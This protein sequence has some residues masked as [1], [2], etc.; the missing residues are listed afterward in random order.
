MKTTM[1]TPLAIAILLRPQCARGLSIP[2]AI[3]LTQRNLAASRLL[4][5]QFQTVD[6]LDSR[7]SA[8]AERVGA[9][10]APNLAMHEHLARRAGSDRLAYFA[11]LADDAFSA[12]GRAIASL[13]RDDVSDAENYQRQRGSS[14]VYDVTIYRQVG[15]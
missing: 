15:L 14:A 3:F 7:A 13:A 2:Y 1:P 8:R 12:G 10:G 4:H 5:L 11:D 9:D 6:R